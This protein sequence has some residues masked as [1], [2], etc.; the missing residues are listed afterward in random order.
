MALKAVLDSL[1]GVPEALHGEYEQKDGKFYL[2][3]DGDANTLFPGLAAAKEQI[4]KE[5]KELEQKLKTYE[6]IDPA[7]AKE[8]MEAA[9]K[10]ETDKLKQKGDWET[11]EKQ[12][13]DRLAA[14]L[15]TRE[16]QYNTELEKRET[17]I[18]TL[19]DSLEKHLVEAAATAAIAG[20]KGVPELLL[21]HAVKAIKVVEENGDFKAVVVDAQNNPRIADV[22][23]TPFT[24]ANLIEEMRGNPIYGRAFEAPGSGGS[25][26]TQQNNNGGNRGSKTVSR[27][28]QDALNGNI[29]AIAKGEVTVI[30]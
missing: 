27:R 5:K 18:K 19:Q 7:K 22:K 26:A 30:D 4:L 25:G 2:K 13:T 24:I 23:G 29:E 6:G 10:A 16:L 14:D 20:A 3:V 8:L 12:L 11:R 1:E 15:K 28:D 17:R 21:P 9:E